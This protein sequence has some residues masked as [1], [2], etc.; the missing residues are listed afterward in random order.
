MGQNM[1]AETEIICKANAVLD[2]QFNVKDQNFQID[3]NLKNKN[4]SSPSTP[5]FHELRVSDSV[6]SEI[7]CFESVFNLHFFLKS[8]DFFEHGHG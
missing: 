5:R 7:A 6:S 2:L 1:V 3:G 8:F 4:S